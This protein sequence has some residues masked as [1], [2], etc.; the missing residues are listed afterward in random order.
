MEE[1][2]GQISGTFRDRIVGPSGEILFDS[3]WL[4]NNIM[5]GCRVLLGSLMK[6]GSG[7]AGL[8]YWAV[9]EGLAAWDTTPPAPQDRTALVK[10][11][12][13]QV[14]TAAQV[15]FW[16]PQWQTP[17]QDLPSGTPSYVLDI[18]VNFTNTVWGKTLREFGLFGGNATGAANSGF[19]INHK[20]HS[21]LQ[22]P[23][24]ATLQRRLVLT[25]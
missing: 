15:Q 23:S 2:F 11:L 5:S 8:Q 24:G 6:G 19:L 20:V 9:G 4:R 22:V 21:P 14:I 17:G 18:R 7:F 13:R 16:S 10:E 25:F 12:D 1:Q 3:G